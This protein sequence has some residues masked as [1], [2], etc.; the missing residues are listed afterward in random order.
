[1]IHAADIGAVAATVLAQGGHTGET[2]TL[3]GPA[4]LTPHRQ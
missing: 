1:M 3:I 4:V 2:L